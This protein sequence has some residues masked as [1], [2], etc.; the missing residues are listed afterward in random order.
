[1]ADAGMGELAQDVGAGI[2]FDGIEHITGKVIDE[3]AGRSVEGSGPHA[4]DRRARRKGGNDRLGRSE[5][6]K[7]HKALLVE[8]WFDI[9]RREA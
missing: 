5:M 8:Q 6:G 2:A 7:R 1:V 3:Q 9:D 4:V